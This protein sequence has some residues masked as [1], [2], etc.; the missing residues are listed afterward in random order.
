ML[1]MKDKRVNMVHIPRNHF[2][3]TSLRGRGRDSRNACHKV[4]GLINDD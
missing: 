3:E 4:I 2:Y 1:W